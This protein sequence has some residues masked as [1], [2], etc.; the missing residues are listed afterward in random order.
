MINIDLKKLY[1]FTIFLLIVLHFID[2]PVEPYLYI[3]FL[4][5]IF[6]ISSI[7]ITIFTFQMDKHINKKFYKNLNL[8][9]LLSIIISLLI[10]ITITVELDSM[11]YD[12]LSLYGLLKIVEV[13]HYFFWIFNPIAII[14][15]I[16]VYILI[17]LKTK[18][19]FSNIQI[20]T[21]IIIL[22][23]LEFMLYFFR[24][25]SLTFIAF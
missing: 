18:R 16:L 14:S 19:L 24:Y 3:T 11:K 10:L 13:I 4:L 6:W 25:K 2:K 8:H 7:L 1:Y 12:G 21:L 20:P 22:I 9:L 23:D 17:C 5:I 15:F